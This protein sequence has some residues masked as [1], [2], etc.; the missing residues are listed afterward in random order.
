MKKENRELESPSR[1]LYVTV[2]ISVSLQMRSA[3][4]KE[5]DKAGV[6]DPQVLDKS[7]WIQRVGEVWFWWESLGTAR[8][9]SISNI[10]YTAAIIHSCLFVLKKKYNNNKKSTASSHFADACASISYTKMGKTRFSTA[11]PANTEIFS[12]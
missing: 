11:L 8:Y 7:Y 12:L 10:I 9:R 1:D 5:M 4:R 2:V 6:N 3:M